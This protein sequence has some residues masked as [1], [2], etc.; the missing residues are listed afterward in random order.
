MSSHATAQRQEPNWPVV[1]H[2]WAIALLQRAVT[3]PRHAYLI[4]GP[5]HVG[6]TTLA[7]AFAQTL[8]CRQGETFPCG[9]CRACRLITSGAHP[10]FRMVQ[11]VDKD[12]Q[13]NRARGLIRV[14]QA[15]ILV[16]D[17]AMR[18]MEGRYKVFLLQ[19]VHAAN[20]N[21][22]NKILKT[23]E[24]PS[25]RVILIL[26]ADDRSNILPTIVSRCQVLPLRPVENA[27]IEAA[28]ID[29]WHVDS[30]RAGL[31]ARLSAGRLGW[32]VHETDDAQFLALRQAELE[33]LQ[34]LVRSDRI[35]RLAF[36]EEMA[37]AREHA[38][39]FQ[40]LELWFAWWR[41]VML[42]QSGCA[43]ACTNVDALDAISRHAQRFSPGE[44]REYLALLQEIDGYL[45]HT[46]NPR[47][48]FDALLLRL[49]RERVAALG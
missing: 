8:L 4:T 7:R 14:E 31:L 34:H 23:L 21:F 41:D 43:D 29:K 22:S 18:P 11:P 10:D 49:P 44:V 9:T 5:R 33:R 1:G 36:A 47:L 45:H 28:L 17:V 46:V 27:T 24:E 30:Q 19:D 26:T 25:E 3:S 6:K 2:D 40:L 20:D 42:V 16:R 38:K 12:G 39:M 48:A 32:A 37:A 15:D 13:V 35:E